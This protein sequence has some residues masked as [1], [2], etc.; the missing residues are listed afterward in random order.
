MNGKKQKKFS[1]KRLNNL[2]PLAEGDST[3][4]DNS[5]VVDTAVV[6]LVKNITLPMDSWVTSFKD[7]FVRSIDSDLKKAYQTAGGAC[8][9]ALALTS[10]SNAIRVCTDNIERAIQQDVPKEDIGKALELKQSADFIGEGAIDT[11][12]CSTISMLHMV[13]A[14]Q[15]LWLKAWA[16][17]APLKQNGCRIPFDGK[18]LFGEKLKKAFSPC[19]RGQVWIIAPGQ[20]D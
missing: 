7:P 13:M 2:Y 17:D 10:V 9:P 20:E 16:V 4:L 18:A 11:I 14:K 1:L 8:R 12:R 5:P 19:N 15:A 3:A 6:R